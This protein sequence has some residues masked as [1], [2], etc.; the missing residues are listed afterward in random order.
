MDVAGYADWVALFMFELGIEEPALVI[1]HS[2]GGAVAIKLARDHPSLVRYLILLNAVG[3]GTRRYPWDWAAGFAREFWPVPQALEM[4]QAMRSDFAPNLVRNPVGVIRAGLVA[5]DIDLRTEMTDLRML[6]V[7]VLAL[8]SDRDRV[9]PLS[10]FETVCGTL[11]AD[12]RVVSGGHAWLLVDPDAFDEVLASTIDI[13]VARHE[14]CRTAD[15]RREIEG[16]L[17]RTHISQR[18]IRSLLASAAPLWLL[19]DSA[20]NLA[21]DLVLCRPP[22]KKNQVRAMARHIM[23]SQSHRLTIA[24]LDRPGL[25]ADSAA[26]LAAAGLSI[27]SAAASTWKSPKLALHSF[28]VS[29]DIEMNS[30]AWDELGTRLRTMVAARKMPSPLIGPLRSVVVT[31]QGVED[32]SIV[33]VVAPDATGL[34]SSICRYFQDHG[35]NIEALR[36]ATQAGVADDTF[37]VKGEVDRRE[38]QEHLA[39]GGTVALNRPPPS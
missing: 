17:E 12:S 14:A 28:V 4:M 35:V 8:T 30:G 32:R 23:D 6:D 20:S 5:R 26:V 15:R 21:R 39:Q 9:I 37:L 27:S 13:H 11:G 36:A 10:A 7:P 3:S 16:Y 2:F 18:D 31:V 19:S 29:S 38:L 25:L 34:L 1:G 33:K 22:L 24:A